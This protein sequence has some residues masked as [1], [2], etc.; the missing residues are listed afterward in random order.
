M[1]KI[2]L[3]TA[4]LIATIAGSNAQQMIKDIYVGS[5][6]SYP[7][8]F[9]NFNDSVAFFTASDSLHGRE[10]WRTD[11]TAAGTSMIM[12]INPGTSHSYPKF[13]DTIGGK[14]VFFAKTNASGRELWVT[15]GTTAGTMMLADINPGS[16]DGFAYQ[17]VAG[18]TT[19]NKI[20]VVA[21]GSPSGI[22]LYVTDGTLGGTVLVKDICVGANDGLVPWKDFVT[23]IGN[24]VYFASYGTSC[25]G[26]ELWISDGTS[27]GTTMLKSF[28]DLPYGIR[29]TVWGDII[30]A[31]DAPGYGT[32][33]WETDGTPAG[34]VIA[35]GG[36]I[37]PGATGSYPQNMLSTGG[38]IFFTANNGITGNE[39]YYYYG[40]VSQA[41]E[42]VAGSSGPNINEIFEPKHGCYSNGYFSANDFVHGSELYV[43]LNSRHIYLLKDINLTGSSYPANLSY[44]D[45]EHATFTADDGEH[46]VELWVT[47]GTPSGTRRLTDIIPGWQ[48]SVNSNSVLVKNTLVFGASDVFH[49]GELFAVDYATILGIG[50]DLTANTDINVYPNPVGDE[51]SLDL[52]K[53]LSQDAY[54]S[55]WNNLGQE[56]MQI[57]LQAAADNSYRIN[58]S[59]LAPGI[60]IG[61]LNTGQTV[62]R[63][64]LVKA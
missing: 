64:R 33:I 51:F 43:A 38:T 52:P 50:N 5:N 42:L 35:Y 40:S 9:T 46:G 14:M 2:L 55:I 21:D 37:Y 16:G 3:F 6:A 61:T 45:S 29:G 44:V 59:A 48:S 11:G 8:Y 57:P 62:Y 39:W 41:D 32:E 13:I 1:K 60:Y 63:F 12:D 36:D 53:A 23:A 58:V 4:I 34:T 15:D 26:S 31:V 19:N 25:S 20:F 24:K 18:H 54:V 7:G 47:D 27:A 10:L 30:F 22:E 28:S 17:L 56:I 49:T